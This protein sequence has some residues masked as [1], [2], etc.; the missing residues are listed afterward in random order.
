MSHGHDPATDA[1]FRVE[2]LGDDTWCIAEPGHANAF[3]V[4]G[5]ER[6]LLFD[7]GTGVRDIGAEVARPLTALDPGARLISADHADLAAALPADDALPAGRA[8]LRAI[9]DERA[10]ARATTIIEGAGGT[11]TAVRGDLDD[12]VRVSM[13]SY[14]HAIEWLQKSAPGRYFHVEVAGWNLVDRLEE[15]EA[16]YPEGRLHLE[17]QQGRP[18]GMLAGRFE[19][20]E[21]ILAGFERLTALGVGFHNPHQ[22]YVD[23]EPER[24]RALARRTDPDGLLNPGKLVDPT[25]VTGSKVTPFQQGEQR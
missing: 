14:N 1:W 21:A 16:V 5:E 9:L 8:S 13:I 15:V 25:V 11:L 7:T 2:Y 19:S 23:Y 10:L 20:P 22:W 3:L 17:A 12:T 24:A 6:A 18:I 4:L